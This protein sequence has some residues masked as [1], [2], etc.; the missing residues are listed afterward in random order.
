MLW[1]LC[2][3]WS[4][5]TASESPSS[6]GLCDVPQTHTVGLPGGCGWLDTAC[7]ASCPILVTSW[8]QL[9]AATRLRGTHILYNDLPYHRI[10]FACLCACRAVYILDFGCSKLDPPS[11]AE[12]QEEMEALMAIFDARAGVCV[13]MGVC[14]FPSCVP[15][16]VPAS[17][18]WV[19]GL[20]RL[21]AFM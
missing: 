15:F 8:M 11:D 5:I 9:C 18:C 12:A 1:S 20:L 19:L 6:R 7:P 2:M 10:W 4:A 13:C 21:F 17:S 16:H 3:L 14:V